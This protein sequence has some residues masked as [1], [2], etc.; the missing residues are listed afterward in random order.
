MHTDTHVEPLHAHTEL[1]G[2][3]PLQVEHPPE[4]QIELDPQDAP[5]V[6]LPVEP[7]VCAPVAQDVVP[8]WQVLP[9]GA[10]ETPAVHA[11]HAPAPH[12]MLVPHD[13]PFAT[14]PVAPHVDVP[15]EQE[16]W[17]V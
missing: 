2:S 1:A 10:Q 14:L 3:V 17:P 12:T 9:P 5:L 16:V 15:V 11:T 4:Q 6:T 7:Q 13:V 8:V